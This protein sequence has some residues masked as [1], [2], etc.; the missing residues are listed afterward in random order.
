MHSCVNA[1]CY[2]L[3]MTV[4][5]FLLKRFTLCFQVVVVLQ[6]VFALIQTVLGK[7]LNDSQVVEVSLRHVHPRTVRTLFVFCSSKEISPHNKIWHFSKADLMLS[8]RRCVPF[9]RSQWRLFSTT[10]LPWCLSSVRCSG[11]CTVPFPRP[12]PSTSHDRYTHTHTN[13]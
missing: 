13:T 1:K 8:L 10:L 2:C 9:L 11:R 7:W 4:F 3:F 5:S 6:Q 12:Q